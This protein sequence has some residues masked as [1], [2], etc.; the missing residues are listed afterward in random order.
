MPHMDDA[1]KALQAGKLQEGRQM[2]ESLR[3]TAPDDPVV[4]YNLGMCYSDLGLLDRAAETLRMCLRLAPD[5]VHARTALGVAYSRQGRHDDARSE[6][7]EAVR[8]APDSYYAQKNLASVL[9]ATGHL[10]EAAEHFEVACQLS[11]GNPESTYGLAYALEESGDSE[12]ADEL[13][14]QTIELD[15]E[16]RF[17]ELA[18]TGRT[19][20]AVG[21]VKRAGLRPDAVM[22][23]LSA[24]EL[25]SSMSSTRVR[26]IAFEIALLGRSG[27]DVNDPSK[28]YVLLSLDGDFTGFQLVCYMYVGF[29][30]ID[31]SVDT[32]VD[33][34]AEYAAARSLHE[35]PGQ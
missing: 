5:H 35:R 3:A 29:K 6:L 27:F 26:E 18:M 10:R 33:L 1:I 31:E 14:R 25:F 9:G 30:L 4:L 24:L 21:G 22:Y 11:P 23:C 12:R 32:G 17:A 19:R 20:I 34:S 2:L 16:G 7:G 28:T 15:G 13:Y 8:L